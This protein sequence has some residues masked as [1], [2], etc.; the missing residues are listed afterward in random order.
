MCPLRLKS[1]LL[2]ALILMGS[3]SAT[4]LTAQEISD[5]FD[6]AMVDGVAGAVACDVKK[7]KGCVGTSAAAGAAAGV[8]AGAIED[9]DIEDAINDEDLLDG[10]DD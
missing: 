4:P 8:V 7:D 6:G 5:A 2:A 9:A 3:V 1:G 10:L